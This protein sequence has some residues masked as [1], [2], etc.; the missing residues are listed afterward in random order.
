MYFQ[1]VET[2][3]FQPRVNLMCSTCTALPC[4][5]PAL[6]ALKATKEELTAVA[7]RNTAD[8]AKAAEILNQR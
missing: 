1:L 4:P 8:D 6:A 3:W 2:K 7:A 5:W